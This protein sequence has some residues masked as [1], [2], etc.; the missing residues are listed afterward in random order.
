MISSIVWVPAG[1][2]DPS[3]KRYEMSAQEMEMFRLLEEQQQ[4]GGDGDID[5]DN[6]DQPKR[7][8]SGLHVVKT[9]SSPA[10]VPTTLPADLRMD[11]YSDERRKWESNMEE[12]RDKV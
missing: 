8:R 2:A 1:V 7:M 9:A 6:D 10:A 12:Y 3:P 11:E 5:N 4:Q